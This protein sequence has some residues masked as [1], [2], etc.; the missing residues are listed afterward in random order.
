VPV[1]TCVGEA[2]ASRVAANLLNAVHLQELITTTQE[3]YEA[4]AYRVGE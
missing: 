4:L 3:D 1:L 2:F